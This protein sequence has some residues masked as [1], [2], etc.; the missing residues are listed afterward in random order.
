MTEL[1][2]S[3]SHLSYRQFPLFLYQ[4]S[5]KFRDEIKPRFGIIR[6]KEFLMKDLYTFDISPEKA[7]ETYELVNKAYENLFKK[8]GVPFIRGKFFK[9]YENS[10]IL[11]LRT[12]LLKSF[13]NVTETE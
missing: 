1:M 9:C 12:Y 5:S 4:I 2:A 8:I 6:S 3:V 10:I 7:E 11:I 13:D